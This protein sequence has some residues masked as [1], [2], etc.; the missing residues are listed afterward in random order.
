MHWPAHLAQCPQQFNAAKLSATT[1][2]VRLG[3]HPAL[4][5][6]LSGPIRQ[7]LVSMISLFVV[8]L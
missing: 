2:I 1:T 4:A 3:N 5:Y 7:L 8:A 6:H